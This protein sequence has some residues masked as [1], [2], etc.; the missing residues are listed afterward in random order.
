MLFNF[1]FFQELV[2]D[3][4]TKQQMFLNCT[5]VL[6]FSQV[7][8]EVAVNNR[9]AN[10]RYPVYTFGRMVPK[11]FPPLTEKYIPYLGNEFR[12]AIEERNSQGIQLYTRALGNLGHP[13]S[14]LYFEPCLEGRINVSSYQRLLMV[15]SLKKLAN[16]Y[17]DIASSVLLKLFENI[18]E[19][20]EIRI[21]ALSLLM[22]TKPSSFILQRIA[23]YTDMD[24]SKDVV[25]AVQSA[26]KSA[27]N[28]Q[29]TFTLPM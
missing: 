14:L 18:G 24:T 3:Q 5:A 9:S 15:S 19:N 7:L 2:T 25:S 22:E 28:L 11:E 10:L 8:H 27:A 17:P 26:I 12:K 1:R 4:R 13:M 20:N 21:A 6:T 29:E 23:E 16:A